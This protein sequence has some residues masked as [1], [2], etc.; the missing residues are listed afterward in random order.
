MAVVRLLGE[1]ALDLPNLDAA[2]LPGPTRQRC[3]L[4]AL[5]VDAGRV[6]S[7]GPAG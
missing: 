1:V 2:V 7:G 4:A 5:A 3:V 6:V